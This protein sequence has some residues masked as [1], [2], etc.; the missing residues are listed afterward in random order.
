[1]YMHTHIYVPE[2]SQEHREIGHPGKTMYKG[3]LLCVCTYIDIF[4]NVTTHTSIHHIV[5]EPKMK[6]LS[7]LLQERRGENDTYTYLF[8]EQK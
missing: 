7:S 1:M 3:I 2:L 6:Y 4:V 8:Q 5:A